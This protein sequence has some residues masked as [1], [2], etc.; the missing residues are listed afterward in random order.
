[1]PEYLKG[2]V[3]FA[4]KTGWRVSEIAGLT[5]AQVDM[6]NGIVRLEA[7][8]T[9]NDDARTVYLD[10]E[11]QRVFKRSRSRLGKN[12]KKIMPWVFANEPGMV[13]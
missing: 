2:F 8:E 12:R 7:G 11:L 9:K 3:T 6:V 4:Y 10:K 13:Q 5:W 1:M